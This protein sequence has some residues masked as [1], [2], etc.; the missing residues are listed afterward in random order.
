MTILLATVGCRRGYEVDRRTNTVNW[1]TWDEGNG[2]RRF[3]VIGADAA[4]FAPFAVPGCPRDDFGR[5]ARKVFL[6]PRKIEWADPDSFRAFGP[7]FRDDRSVFM[8]S[9]SHLV[10]VEDA[11]PGSFERLADGVWRDAKRVFY[12][13]RGFVP[14]DIGSFVLL[15]QPGW[16]RDDRAFY[17]YGTEVRGA[18][19]S[20]F[21]IYDEDPTFAH[22]AT[23]VFWRGWPARHLDPEKF[24]P[25]RPGRKARQEFGRIWEHV[26]RTDREEW[27]FG[28]RDDG[29]PGI[30]F[31]VL[32]LPAE[33]E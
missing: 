23:T 6:G 21:A 18:D 4:T 25:L 27:L 3:P 30:D 28:P 31:R 19:V 9:G 12:G 20:T 24:R 11:D 1:V 15:A 13:I 5:D 7:H 26:G 32:R 29:R 33:A 16:A 22:D 8:W 10:R 17:W 2:T 14:R